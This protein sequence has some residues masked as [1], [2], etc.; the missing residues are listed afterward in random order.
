MDSG[1]DENV[2]FSAHCLMVNVPEPWKG[3]RVGGE[4]S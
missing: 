4:G 1:L 3:Y 2:R